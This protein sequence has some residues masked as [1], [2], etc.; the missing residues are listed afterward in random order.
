[1]SRCGSTLAAQMLAALAD[2]IVISEAAP[3][4]AVV[5][6]GRT[7]PPDDA[8]R[9]L[10]AMIAALGRRRGGGERRYCLK[11]D[12]WHTLA[13]PLFRRAFPDVPWIFLYRDP[14]EVL[15]SQMEQRGMH[16]VPQFL[17]PRF[18]G[19]ADTGELP[20][21][22]YCA[23]VLGA[24]CNAV[25]DNV[26]RGGLIINY[27]ELPNAVSAAIMPHFGLACSAAEIEAMDRAACQDAKAPRMPFA[28]DSAAKQEAATPPVRA[29]A[30]RHLDAIYR[31]LAKLR[32]AAPGG[33]TA[34]QLNVA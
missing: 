24:I 9:A 18:F 12:C 1:M 5:Q 28:A 2:T 34:S 29:A 25:L 10:R 19:L 23:R 14:V 11:V 21:E 7:L 26:D 16:M 22:D 17:P 33:E 6:F 31:R 3:L 27:R 15:V 20:D 8:A 30:A 4:D 32:G 13:L